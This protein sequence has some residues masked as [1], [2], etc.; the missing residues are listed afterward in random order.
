MYFGAF[1][2]GADH[3]GHSPDA[4]TRPLSRDGAIPS[5]VWYALKIRAPRNKARRLPKA[6]RSK[7]RNMG[8]QRYAG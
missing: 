3:V 4:R 7:M 8:T 5:C 2:L 6:Q 1:G